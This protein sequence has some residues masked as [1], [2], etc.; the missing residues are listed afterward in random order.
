MIFLLSK[1]LWAVL[2]PS[3]LMILMLGYGVMMSFSPSSSRAK[4]GR[5][6]CALAAFCF[7][8]IAIFP[9]GDWALT[10][11]ENRFTFEPPVHV[12]GIILIG[13]DE[14]TEISDAR[15]MPVALDSMRRY[16]H[17]AE[18][19]KLYPDATLVFSGGVL[20]PHPDSKTRESDIAQKI[21]GEM[22]VPVDRMFFE[23]N[24]RNTYENAVFTVAFVH[25][26]LQQNWLLVTSAWHMPRAIGCFRHAGW[27][28]LP[29][30]AGYFTTGQYS[31]MPVFRFEEQMHLLTLAAHEY[32]GL[33]AYKLLGR[34]DE[35]WPG[36]K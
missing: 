11:L 18:L 32:S 36:P 22:G 21:L 4:A 12:D 3:S 31:W 23:K 28:V 20:F 5:V 27:N 6:L 15:Q 2:A 1:F 25:P 13:G 24:S 34:I 33:V 16:L 10:P 19:A 26:E 14:R 30:P 9:V 29:A 35:S 8:V 7:L 17:F